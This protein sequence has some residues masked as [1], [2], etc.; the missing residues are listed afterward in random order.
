MTKKITQSKTKMGSVIAGLTII[1]ASLYAL[2]EGAIDGAT[3]TK[4]F[5]IGIG[6]ILFGVG[7]RDA[8]DTPKKN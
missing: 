2:T 7:I 5:L 3:A 4:Q 1:G 6:I 8:L